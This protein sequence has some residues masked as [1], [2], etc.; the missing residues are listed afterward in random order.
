MNKILVTGGA[1]YVGSNLVNFLRKNGVEPENIIVFDN[2]ILG[3]EEHL[4][5][6]VELTRGDL[7]NPIDLEKVFKAHQF[8]SVIHFAAY[9]N[10]GES[11]KNPNKYFENNVLGGL[12]LLEAMR[13]SGCENIVFSSTCAT[14][15]LPATIPIKET[16]PL[17]PI[18]PYG[19]SK[20]MFEAILD[21]YKRIYGINYAALRYFNASGA[22]FGIGEKHDPETHLI[23]LCILTALGKRPVLEMYG[24]DFET[25]DGTCIRDYIHVTDLAD[26][27]FRA[28]K[29][30]NEKKESF[31]VNLGT[32]QGTSVKEIITMVHKVGKKQIK[33]ETRPRR[34]GD[35]PVLTA[36]YQMAKKMLGWI[37][38]RSLQDII[39]SAWEWHS[40]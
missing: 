37:P 11:M 5:E 32:G 22:D 16:H 35:P 13:K 27:H 17:D 18:S 40:N 12:N 34:E 6:N 2:L 38:E 24:D 3:N 33:V 28:L 39:Q 36:D 23:P 25:P 10:V 7:L 19:E 4:P 1:G 14:Y 21:W 26:A 29:Y 15:G 30:L 31:V 20:A 8:E 9:S